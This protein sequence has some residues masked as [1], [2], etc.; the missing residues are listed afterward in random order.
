MFSEIAIPKHTLLESTHAR[1]ID[2]HS[3]SLTLDAKGA[4]PGMKGGELE[5]GDDGV[6][7]GYADAWSKSRAFYPTQ[8][9]GT[10]LLLPATV[11]TKPYDWMYTLTYT[12]HY[13]NASSES[14][15]WTDAD[16]DEPAHTTPLSELTK[17]DLILRLFYAE[18]VSDELELH[19]NRLSQLLVRTDSS[20]AS[21]LPVFLSLHDS[22]CVD[23]VL[24]Q[25]H[26]TRILHSFTSSTPIPII[27]R[28][29]QPLTDVNFIAK[30]LTELPSGVSQQVRDGG[31]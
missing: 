15:A 11:A 18:I 29:N 9:P 1:K 3:W 27:V 12:G 20:S 16:H 19:D 21:Y 6:K 24:F 31:D 23:N 4:L 14:E 30:V 10:C 8:T 26:D 17:P 2:I 13:P 28:H 7:V 22:L 5:E 25:I